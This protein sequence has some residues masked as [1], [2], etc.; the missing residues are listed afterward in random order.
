M[1]TKKTPPIYQVP[2]DEFHTLFERELRQPSEFGTGVANGAIRTFKLEKGLQAT[3]WDCTLTK[4]VEMFCNTSNGTANTYFTIAFFLNMNGLQFANSNLPFHEEF[5]WDTLFISSN[6]CLRMYVPPMT[7]IHCLTVS[8]SKKWFYT[9]ILESDE[10]LDH[11][12]SKIDTSEKLTLLEYMHSLEKESIT[13]LICDSLQKPL[14]SFYIRS[15]VLKVISDFFDKVKRRG[16]HRT[17]NNRLNSLLIETEKLLCDHITAKLPS[18]KSLACKYGLGESTL[19]RYFKQ[20]YGMNL[21]VY[22]LKKKMEYARNLLCGKKA[23]TI[24][25]AH[26]VGYK[27][28]SHFTAMFKKY[29]GSLPNLHGSTR[30]K[31]PGSKISKSRVIISR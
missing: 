19:K 17:A 1:I 4:G 13:A 21:S 6:S 12:R 25:A 16:T 30:A 28:V 14:G 15:G 23:D 10:A 27:N 31:Q 5:I 26:L 2:F 20:R 7:G 24:D 9:N 18:L 29:N 11:L 22:F 8:F 3:M